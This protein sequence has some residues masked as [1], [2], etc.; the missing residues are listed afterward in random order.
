MTGLFL[1]ARNWRTAPRAQTL[2]AIFFLA[3][4]LFSLTSR[5]DAGIRHI[6]C[7]YPLLALLG[8]HWVVRAAQSTPRAAVLPVALVA[9]ALAE[10][11][12]A[13][14]DYMASFN[15]LAGTHPETILCESDLDWGQ[16]LKRLSTRLR[17]L[18]ADHVSIGYFG[19]SPLA[20]AGLPPYRTLGLEDPL[21]GYVAVSVR[22]L[23]LEYAR[24][25][26]YSWLRDKKPVQRIGRSIDLYYLDTAP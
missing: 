5:I 4:F 16:D 18:H 22:F 10:S 8:A 6:L 9:I 1:A 24:N 23:N 13:H 15:V 3:I 26:G 25:G 11:A 14:P 17:E 19:S 2:T 20:K 21:P 12:G 7:L